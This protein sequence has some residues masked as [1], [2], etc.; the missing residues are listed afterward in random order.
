MTT[1]P[2][3]EPWMVKSLFYTEVEPDL[4]SRDL[5]LHDGDLVVDLQRESKTLNTS[6]FERQLFLVHFGTRAVFLNQ[7]VEAAYLE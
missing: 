3:D 7:D 1:A 4:L 5:R 6:H 2:E